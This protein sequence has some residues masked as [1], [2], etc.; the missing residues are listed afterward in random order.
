MS[1]LDKPLTQAELIERWRIPTEGRSYRAVRED[2]Y[3]R[4]AAG[5]LHRMKG[6]RGEKA[7]FR[8]ADVLRAEERAAKRGGNDV[9]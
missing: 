8:P 7:L 3:R 1:T 2:L 9:R 4:M 6:T 5:G